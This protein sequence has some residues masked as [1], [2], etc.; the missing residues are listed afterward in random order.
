MD[1]NNIVEFEGREQNADPVTQLLRSGAKKLI[2][3]AVE[4][5]L[6]ELLALHSGRR[7]DDD[8]AGVVRN[9]YL[10]QRQ[11]QTNLGPVT[12][13]GSRRCVP[14]PGSRS[15]FTQRWCPCVST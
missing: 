4:A 1:K 7:T 11:L 13:C 9:G 5:E 2:E 3:Q 6:A 8:K 10:P 15:P 14:R 12:V